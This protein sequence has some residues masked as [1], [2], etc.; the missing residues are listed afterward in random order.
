MATVG[1]SEPAKEASKKP[2]SVLDTRS[3][4]D[5]L[6]LDFESF[7]KNELHLNI[8]HVPLSH[9]PPSINDGKT[10]VCNYF[11][12]GHCRKGTGCIYRH[13]TREQS[14]RMKADKRTVVCKHWLR[15]LCKK[16][17]NC[18]FLHEYNLD[19]MPECT[20]FAMEGACIHGSECE[21]RHVNPDLKAR[22]C[23]WYARGFCKHGANCRSKHVQKL[24]C[25]LY[26]FGFCPD[27]PN[28]RKSHPRFELPK[29]FGDGN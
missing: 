16:D 29:M 4:A 24:I 13:L 11:L 3:A 25:P 23:P 18:E 19:K 22:V 14:E 28:C 27:G 20:F 21:F 12:N 9:R 8:D 5:N 15:G 1:A 6:T 2:F 26:Q 7:V 17:F 10:G